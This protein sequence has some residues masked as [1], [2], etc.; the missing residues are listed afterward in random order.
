MDPEL[1]KEFRVAIDALEDGN[2]VHTYQLKDPSKRSLLEADL[3]PSN[4]DTIVYCS[5]S[6]IYSI[7]GKPPCYQKADAL[8]TGLTVIKP[9]DKLSPLTTLGIIDHA[10]FQ[11]IKTLAKE[12]VTAWRIDNLNDMDFAVAYQPGV[13]HYTPNTMSRYSLLGPKRHTRLGVENAVQQLL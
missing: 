1:T 9:Y 6:W 10:P 2:G 11:W 13:K 5:K 8:T 3:D 4:Q 12:L 7:L